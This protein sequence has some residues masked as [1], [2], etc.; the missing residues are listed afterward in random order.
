M[1]DYECPF[2]NNSRINCALVERV[3]E[4]HPEDNTFPK[5]CPL[6]IE[7]IQIVKEA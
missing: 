1:D 2:Y 4:N 3:F 5:D 7:N 6:L